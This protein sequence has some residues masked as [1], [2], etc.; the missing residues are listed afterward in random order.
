MA[1]SIRKMIERVIWLA[2]A[3]VIKDLQLPFIFI[4]L[5]APT[6]SASDFVITTL[7]SIRSRLRAKMSTLEE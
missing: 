3:I 6:S 1:N 4:I 5:I 2:L 7:N